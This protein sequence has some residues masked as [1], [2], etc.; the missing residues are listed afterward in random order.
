MGSYDFEPI[1]EKARYLGTWVVEDCAHTLGGKIR[2][3]LAGSI[4][5]AV[6]FSFNYDKPISLGGGGLLLVNNEELGILSKEKTETSSLKEEWQEMQ[7]FMSYLKGRRHQ[8]QM[9]DF[10]AYLDSSLEAEQPWPVKSLG[11]LRYRLGIQ[12]LQRYMEVK[13]QRNR[14]ALLLHNDKTLQSWFVGNDIKPA[15]LKQKIYFED[16]LV[17]HQKSRWL[18]LGGYRVGN[19]NW[20]ATSSKHLGKEHQNNAM[21][22]ARNSLDVPVHQNVS[23]D[24]MERRRAE[25]SKN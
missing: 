21:S 25:L 4:G 11:I 12:L 6:L 16:I 2:N 5:D 10:D 14:N 15:W 13:K 22:I 3:R 20:P 19:Y 7:D 17:A 18:R 8:I 24:E 1:I 23:M 9:P